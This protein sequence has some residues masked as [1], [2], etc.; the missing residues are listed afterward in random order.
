VNQDV[1]ERFFEHCIQRATTIGD[2]IAPN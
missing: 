1:T 2:A